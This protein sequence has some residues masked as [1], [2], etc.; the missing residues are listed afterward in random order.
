MCHLLLGSLKAQIFENTVLEIFWSRSTH[1]FLSM[2]VK[3]V[4]HFCET[5]FDKFS[6]TFWHIFATFWQKKIQLSTNFCQLFDNFL[7]TFLDNCLAICGQFVDNFV[8]FLDKFVHLCL[9]RD[10]CSASLVS[11]LQLV[12]EL[13]SSCLAL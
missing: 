6:T 12:S 1:F 13:F 8:I 3:L 4:S 10:A 5:F 2:F 7:T 9:C 11:L